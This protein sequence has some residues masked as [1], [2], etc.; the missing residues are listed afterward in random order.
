[1]IKIFILFLMSLLIISK[2]LNPKRVKW[3]VN[4]GSKVSKKAT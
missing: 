3:A 2:P 4:A 1:M